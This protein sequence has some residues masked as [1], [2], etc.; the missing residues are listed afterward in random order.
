MKT[1]TLLVRVALLLSL[2]WACSGCSSLP[3]ARSEVNPQARF[4][5]YKT[6]AVL[7]PSAPSD[8]IDKGDY[9]RLSGP[10]REHLESR[11]QARGLR[12]V[13]T[14]SA[15]LVF[16][17]V[18]SVTPELTFTPGPTRAA[19]RWGWPTQYPLHGYY[20]RSTIIETA[21]RGVLSVIAYDYRDKSVVWTAWMD[22]RYLPGVKVET[23]YQALDAL[24]AKMP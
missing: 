19:Y 20:T 16:E 17:L 15:D 2:V 3:A 22:G 5:D 13:S 9:V 18:G 21:D 24:I 12:M 7:P 1:Q 14:E 6:F 11:L 4:A 10:M 8:R 23:V